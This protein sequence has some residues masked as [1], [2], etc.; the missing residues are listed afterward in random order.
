MTY[1]FVAVSTE[2]A[3]ARA[4]SICSFAVVVVNDGAI[5]ETKHWLIKPPDLFF[6][7]KKLKALKKVGFDLDHFT[8]SPQITE[9]WN[10]IKPFL[11]SK[12]VI[13]HDTFVKEVVELHENFGLE[14][15]EFSHLSSKEMAKSA[16][17]LAK[18]HGLTVLAKEFGIKHQNHLDTSDADVTAQIILK[19][20]ADAKADSLD[21]VLKKLGMT[22]KRQPTIGKREPLTRSVV[23]ERSERIA[24]GYKSLSDFQIPPTSKHK[25]L[26][27]RNKIIQWAKDLLEREDVRIIDT[28]TTGLN[29]YDEIVEVAI[30]DTKGNVLFHS[31]L[32][33]KRASIH[34]NAQEKN[35]LTMEILQNAPTYED[36]FEDIQKCLNGKLSLAYNA[37]YDA[38]LLMQTHEK[39]RNKSISP[40]A[41]ADLKLQMD[42]IMKAWAVFV[43]E[44]NPKY[45]EY[46]WQKL[47]GTTH[48]A[49]N[50]CHAALAV[51]KYMASAQPTFTLSL[52]RIFFY[53]FVATLLLF[54]VSAILH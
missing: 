26:H 38:R 32:C 14:T 47:P 25:N 2:K 48:G 53:V 43:G 50:D 49:L 30:I 28:E 33:P 10:E 27:H 4:G 42:C 9:V 24:H 19:I 41:S 13:C 7:E 35:G 36:V 46:K 34:P 6:E 23:N 39:Y 8:N 1:N 45:N 31:L 52:G 17:P 5:A 15:K 11:E 37:E 40:S 18:G 44:W 21:S 12:L 29:D 54:F 51:L 3:S 22:V 16:Y 20:C